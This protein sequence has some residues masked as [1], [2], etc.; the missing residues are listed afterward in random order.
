M[1]VS[2]KIGTS[3]GVTLTGVFRANLLSIPLR[4]PATTKLKPLIRS[5]PFFTI[6][7]IKPH[8]QYVGGHRH[9]DIH[10]CLY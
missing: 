10:L 9:W 8:Q 3:L 1:S 4:Y 7:P 5:S 2:I 6:A